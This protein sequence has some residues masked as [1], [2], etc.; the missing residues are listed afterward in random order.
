MAQ[1]KQMMQ[2]TYD[3]TR[4]FAAPMVKT[5]RLMVAKLEEMVSFQFDALYAYSELAMSRL[6][7]ATDI[8]SVEDLQDF[9]RGQMEAAGTL[10]RMM[11][12][13]VRTLAEITTG[14]QSD[15]AQRFQENTREL[16]NK[17]TAIAQEGTDKVMTFTSRM[18]DKTTSAIQ[19]TAHKTAKETKQATDKAARETTG[20]HGPNEPTKSE[21]YD[22][23]QEL[24]IE[25]RSA[26]DKNELQQA[27]E[28]AQSQQLENLNREELYQRAQE[29]DIEG[30]SAMNR[31][32]LI[33]AIRKS[34]R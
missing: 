28:K 24:D 9:Y 18:A 15:F 31:E 4:R 22:Q 23:A 8:R 14:M 6:K 26:M 30:R 27:V 2:S 32:Q 33:E 21:L 3:Q 10:Q 1:T 16:S 25:G 34:R 17:S 13:H 20:D 7:A 11:L 29:L 5:N 12:N 19:E